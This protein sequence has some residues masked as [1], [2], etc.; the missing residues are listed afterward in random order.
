V[1]DGRRFA[2]EHLGSVRRFALSLFPKSRNHRLTI[3][4][5]FAAVLWLLTRGPKLGTDG[6]RMSRYVSHPALSLSSPVLTF[7]RLLG[8]FL[9]DVPHPQVRLFAFFPLTR[10]TDPP[11]PSA[12]SECRLLVFFAVS[13]LP[14]C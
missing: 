6:S 10:C 4:F 14:H 3:V 2:V 1:D 13:S 12:A 8:V 7:F 5:R 9:S 11:L